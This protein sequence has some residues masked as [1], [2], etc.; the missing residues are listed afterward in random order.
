VELGAAYINTIEAQGE[1]QS[2]LTFFMT[3]DPGL[4]SKGEKK[5]KKKIKKERTG[6]KYGT[7]ARPSG[8]KPPREIKQHGKRTGEAGSAL[9]T[10]RSLSNPINIGE[11]EG[12]EV[13]STRG[14]HSLVAALSWC[15]ALPRAI[16]EH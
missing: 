2:C 3:K 4:A 14:V 16:R 10:L 15:L 12:P 7:G 13:W 9:N 8:T 5:K 11:E 1:S 6:V